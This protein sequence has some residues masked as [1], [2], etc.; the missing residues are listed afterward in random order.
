MPHLFQFIFDLE[1]AQVAQKSQF[2]HCASYGQYRDC[3]FVRLP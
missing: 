3:P 1:S 2:K